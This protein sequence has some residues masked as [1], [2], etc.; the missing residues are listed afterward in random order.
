MSRPRVSRTVAGIRA[1]SSS[2][3]KASIVSR[4]EPSNIPVGFYG[5]GYLSVTPVPGYKPGTGKMPFYGPG[6]LESAPRAFYG[7][8]I[9]SSSTRVTG[10]STLGATNVA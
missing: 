8:K 4:G 2:R 10:G 9:A 6:S 7:Q 5:M 1:R 3:L